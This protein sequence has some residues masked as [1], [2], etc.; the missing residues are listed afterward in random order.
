MKQRS[1]NATR[2]ISAATS[3]TQVD[4]KLFFACHLVAHWCDPSAR[5]ANGFRCPDAR[6]SYIY[7]HNIWF[8]L[9]RK[10]RVG[11]VESIS[12]VLISHGLRVYFFANVNEN[13]HAPCAP[14]MFYLKNKM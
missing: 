4:E 8:L 3:Q 1:V 12:L 13:A 5:A 7:I 2:I 14:L 6:V 9:L 10:G 11:Y